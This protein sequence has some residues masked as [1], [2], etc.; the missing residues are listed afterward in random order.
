MENE[1]GNSKLVFC[2]QDDATQQR[3]QNILRRICWDVRNQYI[4][5]TKK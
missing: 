2:V 3:A 5:I 1:A 4:I